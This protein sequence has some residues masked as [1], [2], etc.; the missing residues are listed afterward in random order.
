MSEMRRKS[1]D[2]HYLKRLESYID[3]VDCKENTQ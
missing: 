2:L 1:N 3:S